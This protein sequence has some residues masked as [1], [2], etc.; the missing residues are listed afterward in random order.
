M[1]LVISRC[2][3]MFR[4]VC[5]DA[6]LTAARSVGSGETIL[7]GQ[8]FEQYLGPLWDVLKAKYTEWLDVT[9]SMPLSRI[10][11]LLPNRSV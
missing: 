5:I 9:Y 4:F 7:K 1:A 11:C 8:T 6:L 3:S 10:Y 2:F